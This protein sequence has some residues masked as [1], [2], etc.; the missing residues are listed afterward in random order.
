MLFYQSLVFVWISIILLGFLFT[1]FEKHYFILLNYFYRQIAIQWN[2]F[3][4]FLFVVGKIFI[5]ESTILYLY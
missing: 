2:K 1:H 5:K 4:P 3:D